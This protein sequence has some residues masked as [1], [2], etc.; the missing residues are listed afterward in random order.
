MAVILGETEVRVLGA[1]VEKQITTPEYYPLTINALVAACNQKTNR[2]PVTNYDEATVS[3]AVESLRNKNL[4]YVF[5][6]SGSRTVKYKHRLPEM[7]E[8]DEPETAVLAAL[9]LRGAQTLGEIKERAGRFYAF[10]DLNEVNAALENLINKESPLA[11]RLERAAGQKETRF[12]HL[13]TGELPAAATAP[14]EREP[15]PANNQIGSERIAQLEQE[16]ETLKTRFDEL[17]QTFED[18]RKQFE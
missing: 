2:E 8:T 3:R 10:A 4:V 12:A 9:M 18:F 5:L 11:A 14:T 13:L 1:L 17:Q 15:R 7:Y 6:G 16:I